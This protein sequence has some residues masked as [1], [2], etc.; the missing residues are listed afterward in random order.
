MYYAIIVAG[1]S[2]SRMQTNIPK[3][4]LLLK[5]LPVMMHTIKKFA[6]TALKPEILVVINIDYHPIW[7]Q[8]CAEHQFAIPH[9]LVAGGNTRFDSV[10]NALSHIKGEGIVAV[11]DAV[12]PCISIET[13]EECYHTAKAQ[14]ACITAVP[15]TDT[16]RK[17]HPKGETYTVNRAD[18]LM[19]QTPQCFNLSL[20][21]KAYKQ[22][23]R[24]EFTDDATV[25][26][27][28]GTKIQT[29]QGSSRNIKITWPDDLLLAEAWL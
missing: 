6:D 18:Y 16:L 11:H 26:E 7:K 13:I 3:Q 27:R 25:V 23:Y 20:L 12:R 15:C 28:L 14:E 19:V 10:N 8:L 22:P 4:F 17:I 21:K 2:G 29:I 9:T 24:N 1:G 5:G